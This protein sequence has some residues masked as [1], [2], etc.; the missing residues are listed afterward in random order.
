MCFYYKAPTIS[1]CQFLT[2]T[3]A[4]ATWIKS[5]NSYT[6]NCLNDANIA[7]MVY[8]SNVDVLTSTNKIRAVAKCTSTTLGFQNLLRFKGAIE[9]LICL[10]SAGRIWMDHCENTLQNVG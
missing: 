1:H 8:K 10:L 2:T 6:L 4:L 7:D 9:P 3:L 5:P